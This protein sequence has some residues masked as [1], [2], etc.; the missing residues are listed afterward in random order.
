MSRIVIDENRCKGCGLCTL[1]C[2][3]DLVSISEHFSEKGYRPAEFLDSG[4]QCIGCASCAL[5][6]PDVA[7][8]VFRSPRQHIPK[9]RAKADSACT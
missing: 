5:M 2:P 8:R 7:I 3:Y 9:E 4:E 6:C 1:F